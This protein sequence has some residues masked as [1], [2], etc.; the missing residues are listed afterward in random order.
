[1]NKT[2]TEQYKKYYHK[3]QYKKKNLHGTIQE[4]LI[5]RNN[6]KIQLTENNTKIKLKVYIPRNT[7]HKEQYKHKTYIEQ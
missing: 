6:T 7:N 3:E 5:T 4:I 2:Y 1:M